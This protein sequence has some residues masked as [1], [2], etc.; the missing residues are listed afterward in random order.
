[1]MKK[2]LL[3]TSLFIFFYTTVSAQVVGEDWDDLASI[4]L[5]SGA[6][7]DVFAQSLDTVYVVKNG[8]IYKSDDQGFTWSAY[9]T[10]V[11][12]EFRDVTFSNVNTGYTVGAQGALLTTVDAGGNWNLVSLTTTNDLLAVATTPNGSVW[13]VGT[14]GTIVNSADGVNWTESTLGS[15][16]LLSVA[17]KNNLEGVISGV[18]GVLYHTT[19]GG[20]SWQNVSLSLNPN[21]DTDI[22]KVEYSNG[23]LFL[24][25]GLDDLGNGMVSYVLYSS[26][27]TNWTEHT[28]YGMIKDLTFFNGVGHA[29]GGDY[30]LCDCCVFYI[31]KS[32]DLGVSWTEQLVQNFTGNQ[33]S[34]YYG[35]RRISMYKD[36]VG[37]VISGPRV[38]KTP[39]YFTA[40]ENFK[41]IDLSISPNPVK[42]GFL[43]IVN[44]GDA[45]ASLA[46][47]VYNIQGELLKDLEGVV[48]NEPL[49]VRELTTGIYF[50]EMTIDETVVETKKFVRE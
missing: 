7:G 3:F 25:V 49:D 27:L 32:T 39:M 24:S 11:Q 17:F 26:D 9:N 43:T 21:Y 28:S 48:V 41:N 31:Y 46:V 5:T 45:V 33:C 30:A 44:K 4:Q 42:D 16:T 50:L 22:M 47:K 8:Y 10:G 19:D 12:K 36:Q 18:N 6:Y 37:Y 20:A 38:Y 23:D 1:M 15:E 40:T 2:L 34:M 29:V 14:N 13:C 35:F